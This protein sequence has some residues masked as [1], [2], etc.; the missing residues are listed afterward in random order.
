MN[1]EKLRE[2]SMLC[3]QKGSSIRFSPL[4]KFTCRRA[5]F[6][7]L[8]LKVEIES[9]GSSYEEEDCNIRKKFSFKKLNSLGAGPLV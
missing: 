2:E 5:N 8:H 6:L 3:P 1:K 9:I 7:M 4:T